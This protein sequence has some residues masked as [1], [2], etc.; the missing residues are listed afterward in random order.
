MTVSDILNNR[1]LLDL[2]E[3]TVQ[4]EQ[5]AYSSYFHIFKTRA[6]RVEDINRNK[7]LDYLPNEN[8]PNYVRERVSGKYEN[9]LGKIGTARSL[10]TTISSKLAIIGVYDFIPSNLRNLILDMFALVDSNVYMLDTIR[11]GDIFSIIERTFIKDLEIQLANSKIS[12]TDLLDISGI[13]LQNISSLDSIENSSLRSI[14]SLPLRNIFGSKVDNIFTLLQYADLALQEFSDESVKSFFERNVKDYENRSL[15]IA[16]NSPN[17]TIDI[18]DIMGYQTRNSIVSSIE[19]DFTDYVSNYTDNQELITLIVNEYISNIKDF[20]DNSNI[21]L[22][23]ITETYSF[24]LTYTDNK[25]D[26]ALYNAVTRVIE[27]MVVESGIIKRLGKS[28]T[29]TYVDYLQNIKRNIEQRSKI[30]NMFGLTNEY[31]TYEAY[32][33]SVIIKGKTIDQLEEYLNNNNG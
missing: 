26:T 2:Y 20:F 5:G 16:A 15:K 11:E 31:Y 18:N 19:K 10:F 13:L 28:S 25:A 14:T 9:L 27:N 8:D 24:I 29:E 7:L 22:P 30:K 23:S 6:K 1:K 33:N 12:L 4:Y 32:L 17:T 3:N 21:A